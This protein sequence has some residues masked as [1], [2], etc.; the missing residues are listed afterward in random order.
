MIQSAIKRLSVDDCE[1][2]VS[3]D[4]ASLNSSPF[5]SPGSVRKASEKSPTSTRR[6]PKKSPAAKLPLGLRRYAPTAA[7][8][9]PRSL[10]NSPN[11]ISP[12]TVNMQCIALFR[13]AVRE[14][15]GGGDWGFL[16]HDG[17]WD[18]ISKC[19]IRIFL[20]NLN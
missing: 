20:S 17:H 15:G 2:S 5:S 16:A 1:S 7:F 3:K 8:P 9:A 12:G 6:P 10:G 13:K 18:V 19:D 4:S 11:E 14:V